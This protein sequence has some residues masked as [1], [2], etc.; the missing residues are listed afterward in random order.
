MPGW[1]HFI[2]WW[3]QKSAYEAFDKYRNELTKGCLDDA[4]ERALPVIRVVFS[5]QKVKINRSGDEEDL[6]AAAA[7]TIVKAIPKMAKKSVEKIGN[8]KQYLNYLFT[9][10]VNAFYREIEVLYGKQ[11]KLNRKLG[12]LVKSPMLK[13]KLPHVEAKILLA[14]L[15]EFLF[16]KSMSNCRFSNS[17]RKICEYI[18][19][20][21]LWGRE[22]SKPVLS[23]LGCEDQKFYVQYCL[24]LLSTALRQ[25]RSSNWAYCI[26]EEELSCFEDSKL[27][28][29]IEDEE[30]IKEEIYDL[31]NEES[32]EALTQMEENNDSYEE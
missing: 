14:K 4:I 22:V 29:E 23:M 10:V 8:D 12:D 27:F 9:C 6:I 1:F 28:P 15:P 19:K 16:E 30:A 25:L 20:Q 2:Q 17:K 7:L 13:T 32:Y 31:F 11:N 3:D 24:Y 26:T 5:T 18:L 21:V